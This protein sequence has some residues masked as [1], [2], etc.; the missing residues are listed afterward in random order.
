MHLAMA[1]GYTVIAL[2]ST[3]AAVSFWIGWWLN[4]PAWPFR[5]AP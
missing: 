2:I 5:I 4:E 3:A 1:I